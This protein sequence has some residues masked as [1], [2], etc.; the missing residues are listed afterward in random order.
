MYILHILKQKL[1][2]SIIGMKT[3]VSMLE[4]G[5]DGFEHWMRHLNIPGVWISFSARIALWC[6]RSWC[7]P[8][9][10]GT[11]KSDRLRSGDWWPQYRYLR[12]MANPLSGIMSVYL[13]SYSQT[14]TCRSIIMQ[15]HCYVH[16]ETLQQLSLIP[17]VKLLVLGTTKFCL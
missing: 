10:Y 16:N 1:K 15:E 3:C 13:L 2:M 12:V 11:H 17:T 8:Y 5:V 14:E 9:F 4:C 7:K 6:Q